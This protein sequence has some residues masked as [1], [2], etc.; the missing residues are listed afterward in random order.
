MQFHTLFTLL[1]EYFSTFPH[2]TCLLTVLCIIFSLRGSLSPIFRL[3]YQAILLAN[4]VPYRTEWNA[5]G[6]N[7]LYGF[8]SECLCRQF[9]ASL[10]KELSSH[11]TTPNREAQI[12]DGLFSFPSQV[13]GES[14]LIS[15]PPLINMLKSSGFPLTLEA[16]C[17]NWNP[18]GLK[19]VSKINFDTLPLNRAQTRKQHIF[20]RPILQKNWHSNASTSERSSMCSPIRWISKLT[21]LITYRFL[22][23]ASSMHKPCAPLHRVV[24]K[25][26]WFYPNLLPKMIP[27]QVH[28]RRPCYDF[29]FLQTKRFNWFPLPCGSVRQV[30]LFV[31]SVGATGGVYK[32]QG[33]NQC[34]M[35]N[36][37]Y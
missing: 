12:Q 18:F 36:H 6:S 32:R 10:S 35:M 1:T 26:I 25:K 16:S 2:G 21:N 27:T 30:H 17:N 28:L 9:H 15:F 23:R 8:T 3:H 34:G 11:P 22:P 4:P 37:A 33:R 7:T 19:F 20:Q 5:N 24:G 13:L 29:S 31:P 14:L